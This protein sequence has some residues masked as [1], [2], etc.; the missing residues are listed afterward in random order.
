MSDT[1]NEHKSIIRTEKNKNYSVI[2]NEVARRSDLSARA[3][4]V[5]YYLMTLPDNWTLYK[6]ELYKH[7]TEGRDALNK[8]FKEL[9]DAGYIAKQP[10]REEGGKVNGWNY[11][12]YESTELLKNRNTVNP[13]D[14]K[15]ATTKYLPQ[16]NTNNTNGD[17]KSPV[18]EER[19]VNDNNYV[20]SFLASFN[21][22]LTANEQLN[23]STHVEAGVVALYQLLTDPTELVSLARFLRA[24]AIDKK[25][26]GSTPGR[27]A[28]YMLKSNP[29]AI[30]DR[31][32]KDKQ[33]AAPPVH[34]QQ[35]TVF[36][37]WEE[38]HAGMSEEEIRKEEEEIKRQAKELAKRFKPNNVLSF[39]DNSTKESE[40]TETAAMPLF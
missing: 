13:S 1:T 12:M 5:Y 8:A 2:H 22:S 32:Q 30:L 40:E 36:D 17:E 33:Q 34:V 25:K 10:K 28:A 21:D 19:Q 20:T 6:R 39:P 7:F 31:Y 35:K 37:E 24:E 11:T 26:A 9:E 15:P 27:Y 29:A 3:K 38:E 14:G 23:D 18:K 16:L 4:G